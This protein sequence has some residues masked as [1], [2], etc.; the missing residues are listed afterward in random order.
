MQNYIKQLIEGNK[1]FRKKFFNENNKLYDILV[2]EGQRPKT[3]VISCSD[4]RVDPAIIFNCKPGELF[5]VRNVANLI[6]PCE[7]NHSHHGT[8]A[9]LEFGTNFLEV[10][11]IIVLGHSQCGGIEALIKNADKVF[12]KKKNSFI[13]K[14]MDIAKP[15]YEKVINENKIITFESKVLL[16]EQYALI[17]SLNN[18]KSFPWIKKKVKAKKLLLHA[19]Y[20]ELT[21]GI[22]HMYDQDKNIWYT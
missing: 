15:A 22:I 7:D 16:C 8:S 14:W 10:E 17:N 3:M 1:E 4:S 2:Q 21:T 13:A 18:L 11:H 20:F 12:I 19:W 5:V 9:A 6:P